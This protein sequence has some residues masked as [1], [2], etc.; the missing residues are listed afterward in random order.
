MVQLKTW[1]LYLAS[2]QA[3]QIIGLPDAFRAVWSG[4]L[5][6]GVI[7]P[8]SV[9]LSDKGAGFLVVSQ[10]DAD[11]STY[12]K[13]HEF[14]QLFRIKSSFMEYC[15]FEPPFNFVNVAPFEL[16]ASIDEKEINFCWRGP[17]LPS[18]KENCTGCDCAHWHMRLE[19][20]TLQSTFYQSPPVVHL[21]MVLVKTGDAPPAES[22]SKS[23]P[24]NVTNQ[25]AH[26]L[27]YTPPKKLAMH[28]EQPLNLDV[29]QPKVGWQGEVKTC[30]RINTEHNVRLSYTVPTLPCMPC[31]VTFALSMNAPPADAGI[32]YVALGFKDLSA[33]YRSWDLLPFN[34]SNYWGMAGDNFGD[35]SGRIV[36]GYMGSGDKQC[37][38]QM[39]SVNYVGTP[40]DVPDDETIQAA[41]VMSAN[42]Q[43]TLEFTVPFHAG[44]DAEDIQ[45]MKG[46][47]GHNR[48]MWAMGAVGGDGGCTAE[49]EYHQEV[50]GVAPIDFPFYGSACLCDSPHTC[51]S[52]WPK[53][54]TMLNTDVIFTV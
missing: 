24:C 40:I 28:A 14:E 16:V 2:V 9:E 29:P 45:W 51:V 47:F 4:N 3:A 52:P 50:R 10:P 6:Q 12:M 17:R 35:V 43:L 22:L 30:L 5:T 1:V 37:V 39:S 18:H 31:D 44:R 36:V 15:A 25:S 53:P 13:Q 32:N 38:R 20:G 54:A 19:N 26:P 33:S 23:W 41:K 46:S 48:L 49:I 11:G 21:K 27:P 7:G 34:I 42:G 8:R